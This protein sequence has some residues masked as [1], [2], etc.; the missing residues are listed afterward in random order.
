MTRTNPQD[1]VNSAQVLLVGQKVVKGDC[2]D[3][4]KE[5]PVKCCVC[6]HSHS[7][8]QRLKFFLK[9]ISNFP[10]RQFVAWLV[11]IGSLKVQ[12]FMR[13]VKVFLVEV[14]QWFST[15]VTRQNFQTNKVFLS[16][17]FS[18]A[19]KGWETL[20]F[21]Q[22]LLSLPANSPELLIQNL[23]YVIECFVENHELLVRCFNFKL[24]VFVSD[25]LDWF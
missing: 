18:K 1:L 19:L 4:Q 17:A 6:L 15:C 8:L 20:R 14:L 11:K 10:R 3:I 24:G 16:Q 22:N 7:S 2:Y 23:V 5:S 13:N 9:N 12:K 25:F 21:S